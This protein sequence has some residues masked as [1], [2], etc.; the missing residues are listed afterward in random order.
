[1]SESKEVFISYSRTDQAAVRTLQNTLKDLGCGSW[2]DWE[3]IAL[4]DAWWSRI[5]RAIEDTDGFA[6]VVTPAWLDSDACQAELAYAVRRGKRLI[7]LVIDPEIDMSHMPEPLMPIQWIGIHP[8]T[9]Y[10]K[11]VQRLI[12]ALET[13]FAYVRQHTEL[14]KLTVAWERDDRAPNWLLKGKILE[15][16]EHWRAEHIGIDPPIVPF[17]QAFL[18]ASRDAYDATMRRR[19]RILQGLTVGFSIASVVALGIAVWAFDEAKES[20]E[21]E[22]R[23]T[24]RQEQADKLIE[25]LLSDYKDTLVEAK[26]YDLL[27][28]ILEKAETFERDV[29]ASLDPFSRARLTE[30]LEAFRAD[31]AQVED[32]AE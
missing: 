32:I 20:A 22:A 14:L 2:V 28:E 29:S 10:V 25:F 11:R 31:L 13:D 8:G 3:G 21:L 16:T 17:Q 1:M 4:G 27:A 23:I 9:D 30:L 12:A 5:E 24:Q 18:K 26:R 6:A 15:E 7:P 19:A